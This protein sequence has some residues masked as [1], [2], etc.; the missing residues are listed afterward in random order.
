MKAKAIPREC[1]DEAKRMPRTLA[2]TIAQTWHWQLHGLGTEKYYNR[3]R[4][5]R[6]MDTK[7]NKLPLDKVR[8]HA[9]KSI[10]RIC[11]RDGV[12]PEDNLDA[13]RNVRT[14]YFLEPEIVDEVFDIKSGKKNYRVF[15]N[16]EL[17]RI[18]FNE[19]VSYNYQGIVLLK[20]PVNRETLKECFKRIFAL[21]KNEQKPTASRLFTNVKNQFEKERLSREIEKNPTGKQPKAYL[22]RATLWCITEQFTNESGRATILRAYKKFKRYIPKKTP[23]AEQDVDTEQRSFIKVIQRMWKKLK[24][25]YDS[26]PA[27][28]K[29]QKSFKIYAKGVLRISRS[30]RK[31][32]VKKKKSTT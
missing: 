17:N 10:S 25:D 30:K 16:R 21:P 24:D 11:R 7:K 9:K 4:T 14:M 27:A 12:I 6:Y 32:K 28:I 22:K 13:C 18:I 15:V 29:N 23:F 5:Y 2:L 26:L 19:I 20:N 31:Q 3:I 1:Q 8:I